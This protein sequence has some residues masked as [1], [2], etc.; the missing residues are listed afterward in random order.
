M[1][2]RKK[3]EAAQAKAKDP[4][5]Q[6]LLERVWCFYCERD[7]DDQKVLIQHMKAKHYKCQAD[8]CNRRLGTA[9]GLSVHMKQVHKEDLI[10][11][12]N[13][14]PYRVSPK[15]E[16]F[17]MVGIPDDI[18]AAHTQRVTQAFFAFQAEQAAL[19]GIPPPPPPPPPDDAVLRNEGPPKKKKKKPTVPL[20]PETPEQLKARAKAFIAKN[21]A[22]KERARLGLS[23]LP[24]EEDKDAGSNPAASNDT[25]SI[26]G[27]QDAEAQSAAPYGPGPPSVNSGPNAQASFQGA[28]YPGTLNGS[29]PTQDYNAYLAPQMHGMPNFTGPQATYPT[30]AA[31]GAQP[32]NAQYPYTSYPPQTVGYGPTSYIAGPQMGYGPMPSAG[33]YTSGPSMGYGQTSSAQ[34]YPPFSAAPSTSY[35]RP[36][37][38]GSQQQFMSAAQVA[39]HDALQRVRD[40]QSS[41]LS[42]TSNGPQRGAQLRGP[43]GLPARPNFQAPH[44]T[45]EEMSLLHGEANFWPNGTPIRPDLDNTSRFV[46]PQQEV[47]QEPG[48]IQ[49]QDL[50]IK[51][52]EDVNM[53]F[54]DSVDDLISQY[55]HQGKYAIV[56]K[57]ANLPPPQTMSDSHVAKGSGASGQRG[58]PSFKMLEQ[59]HDSLPLDTQYDRRNLLHSEMGREQYILRLSRGEVDPDAGRFVEGSEVRRG[60]KY[61]RLAPPTPPSTNLP[62]MSGTTKKV[63]KREEASYPTAG[64]VMPESGTPKPYVSQRGPR[65][66]VAELWGEYQPTAGH[67]HSTSETAPAGSHDTTTTA[68]T[69]EDAPRPATERRQVTLEPCLAGFHGPTTMAVKNEE[70]PQPTADDARFTRLFSPEE[71]YAHHDLRHRFNGLMRY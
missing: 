40:Q 50:P 29:M 60:G 71:D 26:G 24:E 36:R 44:L 68:V 48:T 66:S 39:Q 3:T 57:P 56:T 30:Y 67:G 7:F 31:Q 51:Q 69:D 65:K 2:K 23:P 55:T 43:P 18:L 49:E 21:K 14:L 19:K 32:M 63:A 27:D 25:P 61:I 62:S 52:E 33:P 22:A 20:V 37:S 16:I 59:W 1:T 47:K 53:S 12:E 34:Q 4:K 45:K 5:L 13:A 64:P 42:P 9:G 8:R 10:E 46:G 6:D 38:S 70:A 54:G 17:G 41:P 15:V 58:E 11:I 35:G 28:Y